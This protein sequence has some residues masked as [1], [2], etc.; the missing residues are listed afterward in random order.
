MQRQCRAK[1]FGELVRR[2]RTS[3]GLTQRDLAR[4]VGIKAGYVSY[5]ERGGRRPS[6]KLLE[7]LARTLEIKNRRVMLLAYP[8]M[9][10]SLGDVYRSERRAS[11]DAWSRFVENESLLARYHVTPEELKVLAAINSLGKVSGTRQFLLILNTVRWSFE[12]E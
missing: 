7:R 5:L 10:E 12:E 9:A 1:T 8:E 2:R 4:R 11:N 6:L 3:L